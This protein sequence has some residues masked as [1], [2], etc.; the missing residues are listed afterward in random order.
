MPISKVVD[1]VEESVNTA[2]GPHGIS[3]KMQAMT[4]IA[5]KPDK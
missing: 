1:A 2:F 5:H 4:F 3:A